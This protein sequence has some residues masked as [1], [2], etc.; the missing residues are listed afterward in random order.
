MAPVRR[1]HPGQPHPPSPPD[2]EGKKI[3]RHLPTHNP[4]LRTTNNNNATTTTTILLPLPRPLRR[5]R[6]S[7][8]TKTRPTHTPNPHQLPPPPTPDP[9]SHPP[10]PPPL[11]RIHT[12]KH[13]LHTRNRI[14][15]ILLPLYT[16]PHPRLGRFHHPT[17]A[18]C[19][20]TLASP[21]A[22]T[23]A[24][25]T[26]GYKI[27]FGA[28]GV[29]YPEYWIGCEGGGLHRG[30]NGRIYQGGGVNDE[31]GIF[32]VKPSRFT[33]AMRSRLKLHED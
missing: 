8:T 3:F 18:V 14:R 21:C 2:I 5:R 32:L 12:K 20:Y 7:T 29:L 33:R 4:P 30:E 10:P 23:L 13:P 31:T 24:A 16:P 17:P 25:A 22:R 1:V 9:S 28:V 19:H 6:N 26:E 11:L 27:V 15:T